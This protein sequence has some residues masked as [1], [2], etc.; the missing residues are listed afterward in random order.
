MEI[1][2]QKFLDDARALPEV[3]ITL[4]LVLLFQLARLQ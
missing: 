4:G 2:W 1:G 3:W